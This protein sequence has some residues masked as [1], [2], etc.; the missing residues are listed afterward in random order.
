MRASPSMTTDAELDWARRKAEALLLSYGIQSA[1]E[2]VVEAIA[3][4]QN[5][6][7]RREIMSDCEARLTRYPD[8]AT[9]TVDVS[10]GIEGRIRF[11]IAHELG[12]WILHP[13]L[14]QPLWQSSKE[15]IHG[16]RGSQ[17]EREANAF[18]SELLLPGFLLREPAKKFA[19]EFPVVDRIAEKFCASATATALALSRHSK[20]QCVVVLSDGEHV[21]WSVRNPRLSDWDF[22]IEKGAKLRDETKAWQC[23]CEGDEK[24]TKVANTLDWFPNCKE[25]HR[26]E[27]FEASRDIPEF[28][29]VL[30]LLAVNSY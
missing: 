21:L 13:H 30:S 29:V 23:P 8:H 9:I 4:D 6:I 20:E 15:E 28:G 22:R 1:D 16:Y 17:F 14:D 7:V 18:A 25:P 10:H 5:A 19:F 12:H 24:M 11:S 2:I 3:Y 26:F 27:V